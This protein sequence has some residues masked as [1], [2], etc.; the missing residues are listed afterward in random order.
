MPHW[1]SEFVLERRKQGKQKAW[2]KCH[3]AHRPGSSRGLSCDIYPGALKGRAE[4]GKKKGEK[5]K[6]V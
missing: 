2:L 1:P 5:N 6:N 3:L 4:E